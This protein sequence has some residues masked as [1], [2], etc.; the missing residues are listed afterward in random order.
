LENFSLVGK[1]A[2]VTGASRGIGEA[3]ARTYANAGAKVIL[4]SRKFEALEP[5]AT[6]ITAAGGEATAIATHM[7]ELDGVKALVQQAVD[8]YGGIDIIVNNAATNPHFGPLLDSEASMWDKTF[9]VNLRGYFHLIR[10]SVPTLSARGGGKVIN[11]ASIA[12][13]VPQPGM[14]LYSLSK[15]A[16]V[17]LTKVLAVELAPQHIQVNAIA[18]GFIKTK[19]SQAIWG[20]EPINAMVTAQTPAQRIG[21][22]DDLTGL[23]LYLA[24]SASDFTTGQ[25]I[26]VDGGLTLATQ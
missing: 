19:F 4:A 22:V 8:R 21:T 14:G 20:N 17:M 25:V 3:I 2:V 5:I 16:V 9:D 13:L 18:P 6:A 24:S 11:M 15:S 23:A 12:G 10:E 26:T 1:V 7:G